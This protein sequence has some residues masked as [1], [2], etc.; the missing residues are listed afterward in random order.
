MFGAIDCTHVKIPSPGSQN[1]KMYRNRKGYFSINVQVVCGANLEIL[2]GHAGS[3][4]DATIF[5]NSRLCAKFERGDIDGVLLG[6]SGYPCR[7]YLMTPLLNPCK[8]AQS[9]DIMCLK[10][11]L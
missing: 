9:E 1:A 3:I 5:Y 10:Y 11:E 4:R 8:H 6:N 2:I 7:P